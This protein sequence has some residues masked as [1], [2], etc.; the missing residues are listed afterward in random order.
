[1]LLLLSWDLHSQPLRLF[2]SSFCLIRQSIICHGSLMRLDFWLRFPS[3][4]FFLQGRQNVYKL[5]KP[6]YLQ[7]LKHQKSNKFIVVVLIALLGKYMF[8]GII[9]IIISSMIPVFGS[10][11]YC[12]R[13]AA[14]KLLKLGL[15]FFFMQQAL[16]SL[17]SIYIISGGASCWSL[18]WFGKPKLCR[19]RLQPTQ[20]AATAAAFLASRLF[21][22]SHRNVFT[23]YKRD[24]NLY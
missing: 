19:V 22:Y 10:L 23:N 2:A 8:Q 21:F 16:R 5:S 18:Y 6:K 4:S 1:M 13:A 15:V 17:V 20:N 7:V 9:A 11:T 12:A 14:G 3:P 24:W